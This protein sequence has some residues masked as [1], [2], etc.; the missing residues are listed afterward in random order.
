MNGVVI[1]ASISKL[2]IKQ[3][4]DRIFTHSSGSSKASK[5]AA[6][7][8]VLG[9]SVPSSWTVSGPNINGRPLDGKT[10]LDPMGV[11]KE[12]LTPTFRKISVSVNSPIEDPW[13]V[14]FCLF[15]LIKKIEISKEISSGLIGTVVLQEV[16]LHLLGSI[17]LPTDQGNSVKINGTRSGEQV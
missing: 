15:Y 8:T 3:V 5:V 16:N 9:L 13:K 2:Q 17:D 14:Y 7:T 10:L 11:V 6:N 1:L 12:N 4:L